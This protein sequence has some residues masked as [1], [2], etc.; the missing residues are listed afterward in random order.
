MSEQVYRTGMERGWGVRVV[1]DAP[2]GSFLGRY[3]GHV[4]DGELAE[5]RDMHCLQLDLLEVIDMRENRPGTDTRL[6]LFGDKTPFSIDGYSLGN[7]TR[8]LNH[9][10]DPNIFAQ[11][12]F[13]VTHDQRFPEVAFFA[14]R[15]IPAGEEIAYDYGIIL[16]SDED[17][18][19][20]ASVINCMCG[21]SNCRKRLL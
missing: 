12:V 9:C 16:D 10:C 4:Q 7:W 13:T 11:N 6:E 8:Y 21:A 5:D 2:A 20:S 19:D 1:E 18:D 17:S 3:V 15:Y 14:S